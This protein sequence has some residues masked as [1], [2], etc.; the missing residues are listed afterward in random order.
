MATNF[1]PNHHLFKI[2]V[3][4]NSFIASLPIITFLSNLFAEERGLCA[5]FKD[6]VTSKRILTTLIH[7]FYAIPPN[8]PRGSNWQRVPN[9][10]MVP[11]ITVAVLIWMA[12]GMEMHITHIL[13]TQGH[14]N[15]HNPTFGSLLLVHVILL[16]LSS[17]VSFTVVI[18]YLF[19]P[20]NRFHHSFSK[21]IPGF[22]FAPLGTQEDVQP[23]K[24]DWLRVNVFLIFA[25]T[26]LGVSLY[27]V[28]QSNIFFSFTDFHKF[29]TQ[30]SEAQTVLYYSALVILNWAHLSSILACGAFYIA[31]RSITRHI[32]FTEKL[33]MKHA[34]D[35]GS[36]KKIHECLLKFSEQ[37]S[38][39]LTPWFA[40]HSALFGL[41]ILL[42]LLDV[43]SVI[44]SLQKVQNIDKVWMSEVT[45]S[46]LISIQFAFPFLSASLVTRRFEQMYDAINRG[47]TNLASSQ[48]L[49]A[50]LNYCT[51]CKSGF[52][53]L[54]IRITTNLAVVSIASIFIGLFRFYKE[55]F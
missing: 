16:V 15:H 6:F 48:E 19:N 39:S 53:V 10:A 12:F 18:I 27:N 37:M 43:M 20:H 26:G 29:T 24:T 23:N 44:Q 11:S 21:L 33:L 4:E 51:R 49:D 31:C 7:I 36:A 32:D 34:T 8:W 9:F 40:I 42:T 55:L 5:T 54:G 22:Q 1:Y 38:K 14:D 46:W 30:L 3:Q 28:S 50:F 41:I 35:F 52:N 13:W 45:S 2:F 25:I 17:T 47:D